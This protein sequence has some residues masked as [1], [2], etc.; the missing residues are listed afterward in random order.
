MGQVLGISLA[1]NII[2]FTLFC[3]ACQQNF[4]YKQSKRKLRA[5]IKA[6]AQGKGKGVLWL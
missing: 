4:K 1:G 2:I 3:L 6:E 5:I